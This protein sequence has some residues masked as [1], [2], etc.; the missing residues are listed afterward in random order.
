LPKINQQILKGLFVYLKSYRA[1]NDINLSLHP[2]TSNSFEKKTKGFFSSRKISLEDCSVTGNV[3]IQSDTLIIVKKS[4]HLKDIILIAPAVV[5]ED[6]CTGNFQV[7][8]SKSIR[9]GKMCKLS[10]P[11]SLIL[12]QDNKETSDIPI[13]QPYENKITIDSETILKGVVCYIQTNDAPDFKTQLVL[14]KHAQIKGEVY[15]QGNFELKGT[16]SGAV[17]TRK[18]VS[19]MAGSIFVNHIYSGTIENE[20]VPDIYSGILL[21]DDKKT[22]TQW[23]Y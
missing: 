7:I 6:Y 13:Q 19:N 16:V 11:S 22:V 2:S 12:A 23:L 17:F 14:E 5:I 1:A 8:A 15:C 18:F 10:Y 4:A 20:T 9:M 21:E 3:I